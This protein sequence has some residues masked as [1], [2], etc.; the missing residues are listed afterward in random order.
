MKKP[1]KIIILKQDLE[2]LNNSRDE[3]LG[4]LLEVSKGQIKAEGINL[5]DS[6]DDEYLQIMYAAY[7]YRKRAKDVNT[8]PRMLRFALNNRL[9]HEKGRDSS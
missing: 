6:Y 3:Y 2:I 1:D 5:T 7:L 8:M 4:Y 9:V